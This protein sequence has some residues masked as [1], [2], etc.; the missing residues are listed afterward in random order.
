MWIFLFLIILVFVIYTVHKDSYKNTEYYRQTKAS[1]SSIEKDKGKFGEFSIYKLLKSLKGHKRFLFNCYLPKSNG[2]TT[3]ADVILLHESGIYVFESKNYSGW[4]F[5]SESQQ[6]WTQVLPAQKGQSIKIPFFNPLIQNKVHLRWLQAF[7]GNPILPF[8]SYIV[9]SDDCTLK[10][11]RL[12]TTDH[13]VLVLRKLPS[14][15]QQNAAH[16]GK[17]LLPE[18]IDDLYDALYPLTQVNEAQKHA[19]IE[20]VHKKQLEWA[21]PEAS[22]L[23]GA[24]TL[25]EKKCPLCGGTLVMRT[26][27]KGKWKGKSFLGC[28]NYPSCQYLEDISEENSF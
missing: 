26:A 28:S 16:A 3:E 5:G 8:Y 14:A 22:T 7:L 27:S 17:R 2:E 11:I 12:T 13:E 25:P 15:V 9:F 1:Y 24:K 4:I 21:P 18:Q 10:D 6:Y 19:H 23:K 20:T